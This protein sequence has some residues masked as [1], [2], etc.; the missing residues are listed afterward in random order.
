MKPD[1]DHVYAVL[2]Q[3]AAAKKPQTYGDLSR[4]YHA[5]TGEWFEP[6]GS[7]DVPLGDLNKR[8]ASAGMP[9]LSALV[10]LQDANEPGGGFWGCASNVPHRPK[11]DI[12]RITEWDRI[13]KKVIAQTWPPVLP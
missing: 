8:L 4:E 3:W 1:I 6:H 12:Q 9:A 10:I 5:R 11:N 2:R 7:W 13:V